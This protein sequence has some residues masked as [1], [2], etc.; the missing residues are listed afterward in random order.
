M[1]TKLTGW[2]KSVIIYSF[3]SWQGAGSYC[4]GLVSIS[5][6][7]RTHDFVSAGLNCE[8]LVS[9]S[10]WIRTRHFVSAGSYCEGLV[11][12]SLWI[13]TRHFVSVG[14]Y[15]EGLVYSFCVSLLGFEHGSLFFS[16]SC[17][18]VFHFEKAGCMAL[19]SD[20][21]CG[22]PQ[23][24]IVSLFSSKMDLFGCF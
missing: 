22:Q 8:D 5:L 12:I 18:F 24:L 17:T 2:N 11:S 4:E 7:I 15:C 1:P 21:L 3:L 19:I 13:R 9:I 23:S 10:L 14:S 6:W 16:R 20:L